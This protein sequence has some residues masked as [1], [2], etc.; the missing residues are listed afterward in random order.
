[1]SEWKFVCLKL[2][3][4][5]AYRR[6]DDADDDE[7]ERRK[8]RTASMFQAKLNLGQEDQRRLSYLAKRAMSQDNHSRSS[9]L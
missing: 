7:F 9:G 6:I 3:Q 2:N 8:S 1:M 4:Q 5:T